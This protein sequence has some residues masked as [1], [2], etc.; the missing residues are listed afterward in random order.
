M[1]I[2]KIISLVVLIVLCFIYSASADENLYFNGH[3]GIGVLGN[4]SRLE[5]FLPSTSKISSELELKMN[6]FLYKDANVHLQ[7]N[8][9]W[10]YNLKANDTDYSSKVERLFLNYS[11]LPGIN[12]RIGRQRIGWGNGYYSRPTDF[13]NSEEGLLQTET[14]GTGIS[15][16]MLQNFQS[17]NSWTFV[18]VPPLEISD[19]SL[20][21]KLERVTYE[22]DISI[23]G[24]YNQKNIALGIDGAR[25]FYG[26]NM[27]S[28]VAIVSQDEDLRWRGLLGGNY[29]VNLD[30]NCIIH[31]ELISE[32]CSNSEINYE[33]S[34][35]G[36]VSPIDKLSSSLGLIFNIKDQSAMWIVAADYLIEDNIALELEGFVTMGSKES[37]YGG[38]PLE[39]HINLMVKQYF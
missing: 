38:F 18:L 2:S 33:I 30:S 7:L 36:N 3:I 9:F 13:F 6:W 12:M 32:D 16:M 25:S 22:Y 15:A 27:Y 19:Y 39:N 37:E 14:N 4:N 28:S 8:H 20:G 35:G 24:L 21:L 34:L 5:P 29:L 11:I 23:K 17:E 1:K 31:L 10:D 26:L